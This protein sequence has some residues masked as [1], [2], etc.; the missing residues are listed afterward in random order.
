MTRALGRAALALALVL[1]CA[2]LLAAWLSP[3]L[4]LAWASLAS[5]CG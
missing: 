4:A 1:A 2:G 5:L 3:G